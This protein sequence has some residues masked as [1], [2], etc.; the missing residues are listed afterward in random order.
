MY[1]YGFSHSDNLAI[2]S[3]CQRYSS[4]AQ[5]W[6]SLALVTTWLTRYGNGNIKGEGIDGITPYPGLETEPFNMY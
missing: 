3:V 1:N 5:N 4:R 2:V 6:V